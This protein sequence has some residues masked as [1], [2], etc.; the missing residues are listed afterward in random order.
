MRKKNW[1]F[2][3]II[4][5]LISVLN[6]FSQNFF[7]M[8]AKKN[9]IN[10]GNFYGG[11]LV[12]INK[13]QIIR[14]LILCIYLFLSLALS[15]THSKLFIYLFIYLK[16]KNEKILELPSFAM[17]RYVTRYIIYMHEFVRATELV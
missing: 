11:S 12:G 2:F 1:N 6:Y 3:I 9:K 14:L 10:W 15:H 13:I 4:I 16:I 5:I 8:L 7:I 17:L